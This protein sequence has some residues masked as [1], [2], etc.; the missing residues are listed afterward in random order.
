MN[1]NKVK[2]CGI[3]SALLCVPA[4]AQT[5][6]GFDASTT[7]G[8][9]T[10]LIYGA[11]HRFGLA[12]SGDPM[13][14][15]NTYPTLIS[16]I[17]NTKISMLRFPG[18]T[19]A[20]TYHWA[21]AIGPKAQRQMQ[22]N[23]NISAPVPI[24]STFRPDEFGNML[25]QTGATGD[26]MV[27][28]ATESSKDAAHFVSYMTAQQG[29][30][31]VDGVDWAALRA[32]NGQ[33]A[34]YNFSYVEV[35]NEYDGTTEEYW[36]TGT[37][38]TVNGPAT[39]SSTPVKCLYIYGGST[40]FTKQAAVAPSNWQASASVSN[41]TAGQSFYARYSPVVA[42]SQTVYVNGTAWTPVTSLSSAAPTA[43]VLYF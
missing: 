23:G 1:I 28:F 17:V 19:M 25:N 9:I 32:S 5:I 10:P 37:P 2:W 7:T 26:L 38:V 42:A 18:G 6:V 21:N 22:V 4:V 13:D 34:P 24:D 12:G 43:Q 14:D 3:L 15:W 11:N 41:G 30:G 16:Q 40:S 20:N 8:V 36:L 35:G 39:C 31:T 27:N 29:A 33:T